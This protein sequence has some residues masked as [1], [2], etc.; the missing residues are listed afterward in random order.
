[1]AV[2]WIVVGVVLLGLELHHRAFYLLF[3]G[4]GALAAAV[5]A[6]I[7]PDLIALQV[8]AAVVAA[9][10]GIVWVRPAVSRVVERRHPGALMGPGVH[11]GLVGQEVFTLD[12]VGD[13]SRMGHVRLA[14]ERWLAVS[15]SDRAIP[16]GT[17][18]LVTEVK[19]TTL[20]VWPVDGV[21]DIALERPDPA[22]EQT[23]EDT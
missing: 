11:G 17:K 14:G 3:A 9:A 21:S 13:G 10:A 5:V 4:I 2:I 20:T 18:V 23:P 6:A 16:P 12:E 15:G 8:V 7:A 19:G 22:R 1:M